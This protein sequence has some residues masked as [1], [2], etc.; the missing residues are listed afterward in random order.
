MCT[1]WMSA[2]AA[3]LCLPLSGTPQTQPISSLH[4]RTLPE[5]YDR[6]SDQSAKFQFKSVVW[7]QVL[8]D[9]HPMAETVLV[10]S[11]DWPAAAVAV[12]NVVCCSTLTKGS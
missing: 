4:K 2:V 11:D 3:I 9:P 8:A 6:P 5:E 12:M 10:N 7:L 1:N